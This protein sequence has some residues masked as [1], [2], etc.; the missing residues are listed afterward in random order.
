M[1]GKPSHR[2]IP[3]TD[4]GGPDYLLP[5]TEQEYGFLIQNSEVNIA[6]MLALLD[7]RTLTEQNARTVIGYVDNFQAILKKLRSLKP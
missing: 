4:N 6:Q 5:L 3:P 2:E 7:Q 1:S